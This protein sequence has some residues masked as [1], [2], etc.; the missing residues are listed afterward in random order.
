MSSEYVVPVPDALRFD[1]TRLEEYMRGHVPGYCGPLTVRQFT[2]GQS[3]PTY[4]IDTSRARYVLRRKPPGAVLTSAHAV[5]RE[6]QVMN[7]LA[8]NT[9]VPVPRTYSLCSDESVIGTGF[10]I[11]DYVPGRIF[12]DTQFPEVSAMERPSY[13]LAMSSTLARLHRVDFAATGLGNFGKQQGYVYRQLKRWSTQYRDDKLAGRIE[14]MDRIVDWLSARIP[15]SDAVAIVHGDYRCDNLVFHSHRPEVIAILDW[16]LSTLGDP[17]AD[18]T[19]H[20]M[21]YYMPEMSVSGLLGLDLRTLNIPSAP[22]YVAQYCRHAGRDGIPDINFYLVF[23]FFRLAAICHGIRGRL[24]RGT[25]VSPR[26]KDYA[27]RVEQF[28]EIA[29]DLARQ[30][31]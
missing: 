13:F 8:A 7:A 17:L 12:R 4:L 18:F 22:D 15:P 23:N 11:M 29:W 27:A 24:L 21:M 20:L 31:S 28:A 30:G 19:Y 25:A 10:F 9:Q 14:I 1:A 3:N 26:A 16:E 2:G 5:D 6:Y